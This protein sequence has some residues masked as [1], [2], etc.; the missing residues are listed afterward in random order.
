MFSTPVTNPERGHQ[1]Q[2][3]FLI[4]MWVSTERMFR[5]MGT[6]VADN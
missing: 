1:K 6:I 4:E 3:K 2:F 5:K